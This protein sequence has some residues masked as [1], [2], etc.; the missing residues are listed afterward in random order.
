MLT[1]QQA[2][3]LYAAGKETV[4]G[5]LLTMDARIHSLEQQVHDLTIRLQLSDQRVRQLEQQLAKNSRNSS[6]PPSTDDWVERPCRQGRA[7]VPTGQAVF[8]HP[9]SP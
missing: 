1:R 4:V 9:A 8:P 5:V 6:K 2:E 3:A 7:P